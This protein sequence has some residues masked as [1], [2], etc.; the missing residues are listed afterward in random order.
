MPGFAGHLTFYWFI[1]IVI[2]VT[3]FAS[4]HSSYIINEVFKHSLLVFYASTL[5]GAIYAILPDIDQRMSVIRKWVT[6]FFMLCII[7]SVY[8]IMKNEHVL[9]FEISIVACAFT[10]VI[11]E[12]LKHRGIAHSFIAGVAFSSLALYVSLGTAIICLIGFT[13][14]IFIDYVST[15]EKRAS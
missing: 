14:H 4:G 10:I 7:Y 11:I 2:Y 1:I 5:L 6:V 15:A 3:I 9:F 13:S 12:F 8:E